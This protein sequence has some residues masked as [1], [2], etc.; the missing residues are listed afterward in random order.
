MKNLIRMAVIVGAVVATRTAFPSVDITALVREAGND[1]TPKLVGG[2]SYTGYTIDTAFDGSPTP[3]AKRSLINLSYAPSE[4]HPVEI[5]YT[6]H[7]TFMPKASIIAESFVFYRANSLT[8]TPT[9]I[10]LEAYDP[11]CRSWRYLGGTTASLADEVPTTASWEIS[12]PKAN[13]GDYR[14]YRFVVT[15]NYGKSSG[16][17]ALDANEL[18]I[19]GSV[20]EALTWVGNQSNV[21]SSDAL[22]WMTAAGVESAWLPF[23]KA[24]LGATGVSVKGT[25]DITELDLFGKSP[26][27][28]ISG[29]ALRFAFPALIRADDGVR[30]TSDVLTVQGTDTVDY[31]AQGARNMEVTCLPRS[32]TYAKTGEEIV[33]WKNRRLSDITGFAGAKIW[34]YGNHKEA[35]ASRFANN[36]EFATV[37]FQ[38]DNSTATR[39]GLIGGK[40]E[41]RQIGSDVYARL[42]YIGYLWDYAPSPSIDLDVTTVTQNTVRDEE[43]PADGDGYGLHDILAIS[44]SND[45]LIARIGER[46]ADFSGC[47]PP[48][49]TNVQTGAPVTYAR[50]ANLAQ[51]KDFK[52]ATF[53]WY[54]NEYPMT[55]CFVKRKVDS[56]SAQFQCEIP[57]ADNKFVLFVAKVVL[58]EN[59]EDVMARLEYIKYIWDTFHLGE[60][61]ADITTAISGNIGD[62]RTSGYGC[63]DVVVGFTGSLH[64]D[65][66]FGIRGGVS[67]ENGELFFG[68]ANLTVANEFTGAGTLGFEPASGT[69][70]AVLSG[71]NNCMGGTILS[72]KTMVTLARADALGNGALTVGAEA[73]IAVGSDI[74]ATAKDVT[75]VAGSTVSFATNASLCVD[76]LSLSGE[77]TV[78]IAGELRANTF[79]VGTTKSLSTAERRKL[80]YKGSSVKQT[81]DGWIVPSEGFILLLR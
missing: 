55:P 65:G 27:Q 50:N 48:S 68:A 16:N 8:R 29:G 6:I 1:C 10:R 3:D 49:E 39:N 72:G 17:P 20:F 23:S 4:E 64:L 59:G 14:Q 77:G 18:V 22:N 57:Q 11:S 66:N 70:T 44:D 21:W 69:Q 75:M 80:R 63:Q 61:D 32:A 15:E 38:C 42:V 26:Q 36:G 58:T 13:R 81:E 46:S 9:R 67:I 62:G 53:V 24:I 35:F 71:C 25:N 43:H 51:I 56:L 47:F 76:T 33:Y 31:C 34:V 7:D 2:T 19:K 28:V 60:M 78:S 54:S 45:G 73:V 74:A 12:I 40:V 52:S 30:L 41:F 5:Y 37:Q 79:R